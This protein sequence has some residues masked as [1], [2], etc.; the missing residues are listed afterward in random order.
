MLILEFL[1]NAYPWINPLETVVL[2]LL[3]RYLEKVI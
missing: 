1:I 3:G 2:L